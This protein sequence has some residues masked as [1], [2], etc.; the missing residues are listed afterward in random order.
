MIGTK[1][2]TDKPR[3]DLLPTLAIESVARVLTFGASKYSADNWR[4]V[5]GW[6]WR[7]FSAA[8]RHLWAWK[9]GEINDPESGESHLAHAVY[10]I[11]F[12]MEL[13]Q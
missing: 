2:D 6:R 9:R 8:M 7:Y 11:L 3:F 5:D 12:C 10:C 1:H 4:H 13:D